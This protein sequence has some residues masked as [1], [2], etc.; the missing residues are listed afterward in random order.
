[1]STSFEFDPKQYVDREAAWEAFKRRWYIANPPLDNHSYLCS[2]CG[3]WVLEDE[4]TLDHVL[5]RDGDLMFDE[6]NVKPAHG[7]CNY[8]KG[9]NRWKPKITKQ[10]YQYL[11]MLDL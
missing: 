2:I 1:M 10:Q 11:K 9:S 3:H 7:Y 4:T 8:K 5:G 6:D